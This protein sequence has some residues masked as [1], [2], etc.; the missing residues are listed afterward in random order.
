M[1][2]PA[3]ECFRNLDPP[4]CHGQFSQ[5]DMVR[6]GEIAEQRR[7]AKRVHAD[8]TKDRVAEKDVCEQ[9]SEPVVR[10]LI[11]K[12]ESIVVVP[13]YGTGGIDQ[14]RLGIR[15]NDAVIRLK[16]GDTA[17]EM[18]RFA[19]VVGMLP[20]K[21]PPSCF[22]DNEIVIPRRTSVD[23][24]PNV[25]DARIQGRVPTTNLLRLVVRVVVGNDDFVA[26]KSL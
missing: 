1:N 15:Q 23:V 6:A 16:R 9:T 18:A 19:R 11:G 21:K 10:S 20:A 24:V 14:H 8:K 26:G 2:P 7:A 13:R 22:R 5:Q 4:T 3:K 17:F 25:T 12:A